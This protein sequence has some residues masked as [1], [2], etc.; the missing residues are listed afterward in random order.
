MLSYNTHHKALLLH[1]LSSNTS[2][3]V[4]TA[5]AVENPYGENIVVTCA[6]LVKATPYPSWQLWKSPHRK[7]HVE[8]RQH[9]VIQT[10]PIGHRGVAFSVEDLNTVTSINTNVDLAFLKAQSYPKNVP[11]LKIVNHTDDITAVTLHGHTTGSQHQITSGLYIQDDVTGYIVNT[12][13]DIK[14]G[15]SGAPVLNSQGDVLAV[16][17]RSFYNLD[18]KYR[19][20]QMKNPSKQRFCLEEVTPFTQK[21]DDLIVAGLAVPVQQIAL[22]MEKRHPSSS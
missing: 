13:E 3:D 2:I 14:P 18:K 17:N 4:G 22:Y 16:T 21:E 5:F 15:M 8:S 9:D 7:T 11:V 1:A 12:S 19:L 20:K 10:Q 6:H